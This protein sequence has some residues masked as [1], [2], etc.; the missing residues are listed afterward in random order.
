MK[1]IKK[2][3][4]LIVSICMVMGLL[5][6]CTAATEGKALYDAIVKTQDIKACQNDMQFTLRL[7]AAGLNEQDKVKFEQVKAMLDGAN[8]SMNM[9]QTANAANTTA[10]AEAG[11][12]MS[13]G[14][15]SMDMDIWVDMDLNG[16]E[17]K[18]KEIIK[19][20]SML[21]AMDP[22]MAG[23]EY[24]VMDLSGFMKASGVDNQTS[25]A[26]YADTM[27]SVKELQKKANAFL[28]NYMMQYD[29]GFKF[30]TYAGTKS[31]VTPERTVEA[32]I[33]RIKLDDKAAKKL[34]RYTV[35]NFA[36]NKD[37]M[38]FASEYI[39]FIQKFTE[40]S[41]GST[42]QTAEL[43]EMMAGFQAAKPELI[44]QFNSF[45]DQIEGI[46]LIGDNGIIIEY[47]VDENGYLVSQSGSMDFVIDTVKLESIEGKKDIINKNAGV[48]NIGIDF[49]M[50]SYNINKD[51]TIE[52]PVLTSE[53]SIDYNKMLEA[54]LPVPTA[55]PVK[56]AMVLKATPT[57]SKIL[58]NG[59]KVSFDS[60]TINGYNYF[61]LRD[62]AKAV[63]GT[64]KQFDVTWDG[65]KKIIS[66][67]SNKAYSA[68]DGII[69]PGD[70]KEKTPVLNTSIILKDGVEVP[71]IGY[72]INGN[73]Y[74]KLR[75]IAE[76]FDIGITWDGTTNTIEINTATG[77]AAP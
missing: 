4:V 70:G 20:P 31:I 43:E 13:F 23:K 30:I 48:Y 29:P 65:E 39:K 27:K 59:K 18:F 7:D 16:T 64:Q 49:R 15:M 54:Q 76:V 36:D 69:K 37:A 52:M 60:Y 28:S 24:M 40:S 3:M 21:T 44:A 17:P 47:A 2:V 68:P 32:H 9:K 14:G 66:L 74:F 62:L 67:I 55:E 53:N 33:Y 75:E 11:M 45:M 63:R 46:K 10:K 22:S 5:S 71:F 25:S 72:T 56:P 73:N 1:N 26:D 19:F 12:N 77:Y 51:M 42:S 34:V 41:I 61:K 50:L 38:D 35:N 57:A 6:G 8:I 58:L